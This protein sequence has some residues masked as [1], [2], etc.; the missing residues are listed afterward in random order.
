MEKNI[1]RKMNDFLKENGF[2]LGIFNMSPITHKIGLPTRKYSL[3]KPEYSPIDGACTIL[4]TPISI[5]KYTLKIPYMYNEWVLVVKH[6]YSNKIKL[7]E[8]LKEYVPEPK[9]DWA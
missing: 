9:G 2:K 5:S 1:I 4:V 3:V 8:L 6:S 7:L